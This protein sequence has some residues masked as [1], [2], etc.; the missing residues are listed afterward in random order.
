MEKICTLAQRLRQ[1]LELRDMTQTELARRSGISK[2]SISR[3]VKGDW[4]GKAEAVRAMAEALNV[5]ERWLSGCN[6]PMRRPD[7]AAPAPEEIPGAILMPRMVPRPLLGDI[8]CGVP[9]LAVENIAGYV[10]VPEDIPCD[11]VLRCKGDSMIHAHILDGSLV[12]IRACPEVA[13]GEIAAVVIGD[14]A[15]LKRVYPE[16]DGIRLVAENPAYAPLIYTGEEAADVRILGTVTAWTNF[17][18]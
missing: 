15:T 10:M 17:L 1:A 8:A 4:V 2:S 13:P 6:A 5:S 14:E 9:L 7:D 16:T 18:A 11:F 12:Y 3:Y